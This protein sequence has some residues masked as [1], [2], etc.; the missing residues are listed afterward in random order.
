M[1]SFSVRLTRDAEA[2]LRAAPFPVRRQLNQRLFKLKNHPLPPPGD[3]DWRSVPG[4]ERPRFRLM[5]YGW[6][7]L[8]E[9]EEGEGLV[10]VVAILRDGV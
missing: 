7:I 9:F 8:Y 1:G 2:E 10:T 3:D 6:K 4:G 5:A